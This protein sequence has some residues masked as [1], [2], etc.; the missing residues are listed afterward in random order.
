M[1]V[2]F[3]WPVTEA[4]KP[5]SELPRGRAWALM[6]KHIYF[7]SEVIRDYFSAHYRDDSGAG[8]ALLI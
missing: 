2:N 6:R 1:K 5:S 8:T 4:A 3:A 7:M